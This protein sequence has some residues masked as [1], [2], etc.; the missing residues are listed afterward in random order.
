MSEPLRFVHISDTH[1]G[2]TKEFS[3]YGCNPYLNARRI[4]EAINAIPTRPDFVVH[5]G[6]ITSLPDDDA[7]TLAADVFARLHVPIYYVT[8]NHDVSRCI[9]KHLLKEEVQFA[10]DR[11]DLLSY[12]FEKRGVRFVAL[13]AR[14]PDEIDPH[15][16][17]AEHQFAFLRRELA[18]A[19]NNVVILIHFPPFALDSTWLDEAMLLLNGEEF[20]QALIPFRNNIR[21]VFFGHVHRGMQVFRDG[22]LYSSV[23]STIGQF[24]S[25]PAH[26]KVE[27]D[28]VHPPCFN[29]VTLADGKTIIKELSI[30]R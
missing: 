25:W 6:D 2:P 28:E 17:L 21:G 23:A 22:I 29:F 4:V 8:G 27:Q 5:T 11:P 20:H 7:Y 24:H 14:G 10:S 12:T 13:D 9:R 3:L 19:E 16:I 1:F 15:G 30:S 18:A 26:A